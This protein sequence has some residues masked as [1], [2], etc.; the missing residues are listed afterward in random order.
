MKFDDLLVA[1]F[2][3]L[4]PSKFIVN[5]MPPKIFLC[6]GPT[7]GKE[8]I[9]QSMRQRII[10]HFVKSDDLLFKSIIHAENFKDY[11][12]DAVYEDLMQFEMDIAAISTLIIICLESAGALVE[13]GLFCTDVGLAKRLLVVVPEEH[14]A[15]EDSFI[16]LG[17]LQNLSTKDKS[18]VVVYPWPSLKEL[19]YEHIEFVAKDLICKLDGVRKSEK[20][21]KTKLSHIAFLAYE[22]ILISNPILLS[23][24]ELALYACDIDV[25]R[26]E[27]I[28]ILYLLEK[29]GL[30]G[31]IVYSSVT[32]YFDMSGGERRINFGS[33]RRGIVKELTPM[34]IAFRKTYVM[35]EDE[36]SKKRC[37][38]IKLIVDR[39]AGKK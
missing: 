26:K 22:I 17:P 24:I 27:I 11:F 29:I 16:H 15:K 32:Y 25:D 2:Q 39:K 9:P 28:R 21:K 37:N 35:A 6:G 12:K 1:E 36:Q 3:S 33:D 14:V 13:L 4:D 19:N 20:F 10:N 7:G 34:R 5:F 38:V 18:S 31:H 8:V 23:E 30:I